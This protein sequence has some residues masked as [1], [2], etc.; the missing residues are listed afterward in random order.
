MEQAQ[1]SAAKTVRRVLA[2][3]ALPAA[4]AEAEEG[5][6]P[7]SMVRELS[8]GTL[9]FLGELRAIVRLLAE[10]PL[11]DANAGVLDPTCVTRRTG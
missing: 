6:G 11:A 10:R 1:R 8:Y 7:R 2:G 3:A 9:R 5:G 4:L